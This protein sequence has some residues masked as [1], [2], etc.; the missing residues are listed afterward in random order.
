M[1]PRGVLPRQCR[2]KNEC[3]RYWNANGPPIRS[4]DR[5]LG[6]DDLLPKVYTVG[7]DLIVEVEM[8]RVEAGVRADAAAAQP[9]V[10]SRPGVQH[11][12]E[13]LSRHARRQGLDPEVR[14][15]IHHRADERGLGGIID[16]CRVSPVVSDGGLAPESVG[17]R[18][19]EADQTVLDE[20]ADGF[21]EP[22][23]CATEDGAGRNDV[24]GVA[25][26]DLGD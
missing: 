26:M 13:I 1:M 22:S 21:V 24:P 3:C 11:K 7:D 2:C 4:C 15:G 14:P 12:G 5:K 9:Q 19:G 20:I 23:C 16:G 6:L 18:V 8:R 10:T 25:R 17:D